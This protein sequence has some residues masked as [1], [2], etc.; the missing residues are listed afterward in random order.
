MASTTVNGEVGGSAART[1]GKRG[2]GRVGDAASGDLVFTSACRLVR[3][4]SE[5]LSASDAKS[6]PSIK[7]SWD[8]KLS[9]YIYR[10]K[11][12]LLSSERVSIS[13]IG[14]AITSVVMCAE[15]LRNE[16]FVDIVS[17]E[18]SMLKS[19]AQNAPAHQKPVVEIVVERTPQ[20]HERMEAENAARAARRPDRE[21]RAA[22]GAP[23]GRRGGGNAR[24]AADA[25]PHPRDG[26]EESEENEDAEHE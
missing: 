7:V 16:G 18:T 15:I 11:R 3:D 8:Q 25:R 10:T 20:F 26:E 6:L 23:S 2:T 4:H 17:I 22:T 9:T 1:G 21:R 12:F 13:G 24:S 5:T 14:M 19:K